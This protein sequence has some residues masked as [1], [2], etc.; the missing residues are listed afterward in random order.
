MTQPV[1]E[2]WSQQWD[3]MNDKMS[4]M[5]AGEAYVY[6]VMAVMPGILNYNESLMADDAY[7]MSLTS[8]LA[9]ELKQINVYFNEGTN[10]STQDA[11]NAISLANQMM[12]QVYENPELNPLESQMEADLKTIFPPSTS[13]D[14]ADPTGV[15][16]QTQSF[17]DNKYEIPQIQT[18]DPVSGG[19]SA[20]GLQNS[21]SQAWAS[22]SASSSSES[23]E[24]TAFTNGF[25]NTYTDVN[26]YS[27]TQ[28][29]QLK[30]DESNDQQYEGTFSSMEQQ[31]TQGDSVFVNNETAN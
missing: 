19:S 3:E 16:W 6:I 11:N 12:Q 31:I 20:Q 8:T 7:G 29:V 5:S 13:E 17:D 28:Q 14:S 1:Q 26:N 15:S 25:S 10:I 2:N 23:Y 18:N 22:G 4:H 27:N 21:W 24:M 9:S 30:S